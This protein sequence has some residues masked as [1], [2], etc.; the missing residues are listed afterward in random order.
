MTP[1]GLPVR[2]IAH[3]TK[4]SQ[5]TA[6]DAG[7]NSKVLLGFKALKMQSTLLEVRAM[8]YGFLSSESILQ[9]LDLSFPPV[10]GVQSSLALQAAVVHACR[11]QEGTLFDTSV[12][13]EEDMQC[14]PVGR[15][16]TCRGHTP[17]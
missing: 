3:T 12:E 4:A 8:L 17:V 16:I 1:A 9:A 11:I 10:P 2:C 14:L 15:P 13:D 5:H 7:G 6:E